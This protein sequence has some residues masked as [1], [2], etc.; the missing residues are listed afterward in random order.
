MVRP[1]IEWRELDGTLRR[2]DRAG[3]SIKRQ[4]RKLQVSERAVYQRRSALG[5]G[6]KRKNQEPAAH[7]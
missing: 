1:A 7:A 4:A 2:M 3:L 5:L 6:R